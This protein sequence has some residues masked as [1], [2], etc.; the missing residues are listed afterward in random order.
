MSD[1]CSVVP[2]AQQHDNDGRHAEIGWTR[3]EPCTFADCG[4]LHDNGGYHAAHGWARGPRRALYQNG[5]ECTAYN[6]IGHHAADCPQLS[7]DE[8]A[9]IRAAA[10]EAMKRYGWLR[11]WQRRKRGTP[12]ARQ[13]AGA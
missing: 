2:C 11:S 6:G 9:A 10:D 3:G 12:C 13:N 7:A 4:L 5:G 8:L 1:T